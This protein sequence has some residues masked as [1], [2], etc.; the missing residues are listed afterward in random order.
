MGQPLI[1][2]ESIDSDELPSAQVRGGQISCRSFEKRTLFSIYCE[3]LFS[4]HDVSG[5]RL[6]EIAGGF[7]HHG[8]KP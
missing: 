7:F 2:A 5:V 6:N 1:P 3:I 8:G 4:R